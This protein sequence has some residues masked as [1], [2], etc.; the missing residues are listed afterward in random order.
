MATYATL[1]ADVATWAR[2][3]DLTSAI[4][5]FVSLAEMEIY[6]THQPPLRVREMETESSLTVTALTAAVPANYL[7]ARYIKLDN[8]DRPTIQYMAP[9][10]WDQ[11]QSGFFTVV[12]DEI[13]LPADTSSNLKLVYLAQPAALVNDADTNDVLNAY[14]GIYL[15]ATLKYAAAY[16]KDYASRDTFQ[17]QL[18]AFIS[19]AI[20]NNKPVAAGPLTVQ[21]G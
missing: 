7:E 1:K 18:D 10:K 19:G 9:S 6:K 21:L 5:A 12:G 4:P 8:T 20:S 15:S 11:Y 16:V 17:L 14:Y 2:R 3:S 13:R